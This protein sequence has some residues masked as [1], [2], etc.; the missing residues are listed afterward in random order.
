MKTFTFNGKTS[1]ELGLVIKNMPPVPRAERDITSLAISGK[2][3]SLHIDNNSW[4]SK[5]YTIECICKDTTK[6]DLLK[7][8]L[9]GTHK[10]TLSTYSDREFI[11]TIK[12]QIDFDNY[13]TYLQS[14]PLELELQP[15]GY[16]T[17]ET[18]TTIAKEYVTA[19]GEDITL[20]NTGVAPLEIGLKGNTYQETTTGK[21]LFNY[22]T[23]NYVQNETIT[24]TGTGNDF[25]VSSTG[26]GLRAFYVCQ[27]DFATLYAYMSSTYTNAS[28]ALYSTNSN[29]YGSWS[30]F[31]HD[32]TLIQN[33]WNITQT[34]SVDLSN[35]QGKYLWITLRGSYTD[36][37]Y[38]NVNYKDFILSKEQVSAYEEYT[39][40]I[41]APNPDFPMPVQVVTGDNTIK[42][43]NANLLNRETCT[44]D[45]ALTWV[46]GVLN[47]ETNS[48]ASDYMEVKIGE[49]YS[50]T[51]FAQIMFYDS[52]KTYLGCLQSNGTTIAKATGETKKLFT[53][54]SVDE[55][56]YMRLGFR[57]TSENNNVDMTTAN[58]MVNKGN[59]LLTY[60]PH[61]EQEYE[62][63]LGTLELCK[64]G[65]YQDYL[66]KSGENWYK[67]T[68]I[69]KIVLDGSAD[70]SWAYRNDYSAFYINNTTSKGTNAPVSN[71]FKGITSGITSNDN[72][73]L[74]NTSTLYLI[75]HAL[76]GVVS[77]L[78]T[79]L[80][81]HN[82]IVYYQL[83]TPTEEQ[84]TN[85]EL[86]EQLET[87]L[88]AVSYE[89]QTNISQENDN[90][91]FILDVSAL[92]K[93][94]DKAVIDNT[95]NV[96]IAPIITVG[97]QGTLTVNGYSIET[98]EDNITIDCEL[99][100]C[101]NGTIAKNNKVILS[102]FP[103]LSVG[104]N[105]VVA[106][107]AD[108]IT[109]KHKRGWL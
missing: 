26:Y 9:W 59:T 85:A 82:T 41:P 24:I 77:D 107:T 83:S 13:L 70:E 102:E 91:A 69:G 97:S 72:A 53:V 30:D 20:N 88:N 92:K 71:Y 94:S 10:L 90:M 50:T 25:T 35:Y 62:I 108:N 80:G 105:N 47:N 63:N 87:I 6:A 58:I 84:I 43:Q 3:G 57:A 36:S 4:K 18:T 7:S 44:E 14:F 21:Q 45:K 29:S 46:G 103:V 101:Y 42:V 52:S 22:A 34:S 89:D 95:G 60:I 56:A 16:D 104:N 67:H 2:S 27:I 12:N 39:G 96:E 55:I 64:I 54:P 8:T 106:Q 32:R 11:A 49:Q 1:D 15:F 65:T 17:T 79:W 5:R 33:N 48:L 93:N 40:G 74:F 51:Y 19:Q 66:Y 23:T 78:Q 68:E 109:I 75:Y 86:I 61:Q 81:T 76:N 37:G 100:E 31:Y 38:T 98:T 73:I 99:M 28:I